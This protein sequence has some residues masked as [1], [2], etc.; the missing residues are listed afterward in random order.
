MARRRKYRLLLYGSAKCD[1]ENA[2]SWVQ[3]FA[4]LTAGR[5]LDQFT[6]QIAK[7]EYSADSCGTAAERRRSRKVLRERLY[8]RR[9]R[10]F[11]VIFFIEGEEI[12]VIGI[13]RGQ[14]RGL[15]RKQIDSALET[16]PPDSPPDAPSNGASN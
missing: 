11:R 15:T 1:L 12:H 4:P 2:F 16:R 9:P 8:G 14:R 7:L 10:V 6:A 3:Q 13:R 5:W